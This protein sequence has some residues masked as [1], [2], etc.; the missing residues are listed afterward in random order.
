[1]LKKLNEEGSIPVFA[2]GF[3]RA[4]SDYSV[5]EKSGAFKTKETIKAMVLKHQEKQ[6]QTRVL[7][8]F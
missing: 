8:G 4:R 7:Q 3:C 6:P 2:P 5:P 1:M